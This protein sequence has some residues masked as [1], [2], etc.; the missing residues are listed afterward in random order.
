MFWGTVFMVAG[1]GSGI[2]IR[3]HIPMHQHS[4]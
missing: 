4:C 1:G 2:A 3:W